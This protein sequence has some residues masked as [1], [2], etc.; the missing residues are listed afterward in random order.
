M[1]AVFINP[2]H[3][4]RYVHGPY[5]NRLE[6]QAQADTLRA[7]GRAVRV[8]PRACSVDGVACPLYFVT[9]DATQEETGA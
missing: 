2:I 8:R 3:P 5:L 1:S 6:A 4:H 9:V 7:P